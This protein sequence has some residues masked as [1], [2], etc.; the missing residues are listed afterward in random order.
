MRTYGTPMDPT[1][2]V[3]DLNGISTGAGVPT[4]DKA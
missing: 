3:E 2:V 1:D 4:G